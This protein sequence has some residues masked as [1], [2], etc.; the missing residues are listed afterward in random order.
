MIA[1]NNM[2]NVTKWSISKE[3]KNYKEMAE[4]NQKEATE[5]MET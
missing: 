5:I 2:D 4:N 1:E 3:S